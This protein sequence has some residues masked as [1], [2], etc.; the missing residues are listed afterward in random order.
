MT[1]WQSGPPASAAGAC[2]CTERTER[3]D[4][5]RGELNE[6]VI[7]GSVQK[8]IIA[9][10]PS[11]YGTRHRMIFEFARHIY[12]MPQYTDADPKD[13]KSFVIEWHRQALPYIRTEEFEETWIDFLKAWPK[14]KKKVGEEPMTKIFERAKKA[15]PPQV[16]VELHPDNKQLQLFITLCRELQKEAGQGPF[17]LACRTGGKYFNVAPMTISRWFFLLGEESIVELVTKGGTENNPR[18]ASRYKYLGNG[19]PATTAYNIAE[20]EKEELK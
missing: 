3:T 9:T 14:I 16:A 8:A 2:P 13:L 15:E 20:T 1:L 10:L 11:E 6:I 4:E 17:F 18:K 12:S 5:N 7:E 19:K